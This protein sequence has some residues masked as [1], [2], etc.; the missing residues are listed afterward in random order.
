MLYKDWLNCFLE[1]Y[2][3][4]YTKERTYLKYHQQMQ[5]Y[6]I[7]K[8][9]DYDVND[10]SALTLQEFSSWLK[11]L[12]LATNTINFIISILKSSLKKGVD[13]GI[14]EKQYSDIIARPKKRPNKISCFSFEEQKKI[15]KYILESKEPYYFGILLCLYTGL[16]IGELLCLTWDDID[17]YNHSISITKSCYDRWQ[18]GHYIKV[19]ETPKTRSSERIIPLPKCLI[20]YLKIH[21]KKTKSSF[22]IFGKKDNGVKIRSYQRSFERLLKRLNIPHKGFHS[23]RH[24]F[25]TRALEIGM[26]VKTLSEILGHQNPT[27]TLERYA[28]SLMEHKVDMMNRLGRLLI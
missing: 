3:K 4:V 13:L 12:N 16:R 27:I 7:P 8:L 25:A 15:E 2:I 19:I 26:D 1:L 22:V 6:I 17:F 21:H 18:N 24:T 14:I 10:L 11:E 9:G 20:S 23:L 5:K 28:H